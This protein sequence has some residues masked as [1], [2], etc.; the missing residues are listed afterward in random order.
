VRTLRGIRSAVLRRQFVSA[1]DRDV[2]EWELRS[3][4]GAE[5]AV[6]QSK[7][8]LRESDDGVQRWG[9]PGVPDCGEL[10][11][12]I[13]VCRWT[14]V[15]FPDTRVRSEHRGDRRLHLLRG[16]GRLLLLGQ[17]LHR[18]RLLRSGLLRNANG[19]PWVHCRRS[20][21]RRGSGLFGWEL[22]WLWRV[23]RAVL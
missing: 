13:L 4:R 11:R 15:L 5:S 21:V 19:P 20:I 8:S 12:R 10:L 2:C 9:L 6:L 18:R 22:R 16:T 1:L 3:L 23:G 17:P 14:S 7:R